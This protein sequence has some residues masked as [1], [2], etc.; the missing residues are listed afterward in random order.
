MLLVVRVLAVMMLSLYFCIIYIAKWT[1]AVED[2][3]AER[4]ESAIQEECGE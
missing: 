1:Q 2:V 4:E 3:E